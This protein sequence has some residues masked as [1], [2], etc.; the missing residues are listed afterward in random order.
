MIGKQEI[1]SDAET[2]LEFQNILL[3]LEITI[4]TNQ[5]SNMNLLI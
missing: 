3:G 2:L 1:L 5:I 4:Y